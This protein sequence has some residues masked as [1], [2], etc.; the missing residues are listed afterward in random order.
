VLQLEKDDFEEGAMISAWR[1]DTPAR[2][3]PWR[4]ELAQK[5]ID[6]AIAHHD[7]GRCKQARGLAAYA[8]SVLRG[9][10]DDYAAAVNDGRVA[11]VERSEL[12]ERLVSDTEELLSP[13][14]DLREVGT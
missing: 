14:R 10:A 3:V 2:G 1:P 8:R 13:E 5:L 12:L 9:H 4:V 7:A 11:F 6:R